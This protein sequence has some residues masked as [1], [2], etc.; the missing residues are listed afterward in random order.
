MA[1]RELSPRAF[2]GSWGRGRCCCVGYG[3]RYDP[4]TYAGNLAFRSQVAD[5]AIGTRLRVT[6]LLM[7]WNSD[8]VPRDEE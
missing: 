7:R 2:T 1:C 4:M 8:L 5:M 3:P 6:R